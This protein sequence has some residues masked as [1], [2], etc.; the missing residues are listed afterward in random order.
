[1]WCRGGGACRPAGRPT[2][3]CRP[4][5]ARRALG[6]RLSPFDGGAAIGA[7]RRRRALFRRSRTIAHTTLGE[8]W[9]M[10]WSSTAQPAT[11]PG[12]PGTEEPRHHGHHRRSAA[13]RTAGQHDRGTE[14]EPGQREVVSQAHHPPSL[15]ASECGTGGHDRGDQ[16]GEPD[17][18][19]SSERLARC[20]E[21]LVERSGRAGDDHGR[22]HT[23]HRP[24]QCA[25]P[26]TTGDRDEPFD[27]PANEHRERCCQDD[28]RDRPPLP[29]PRRAGAAARDAS[30]VLTSFSIV[31]RRE[32]LSGSPTP[33]RR[34]TATPWTVRRSSTG[35]RVEHADR[36]AELVLRGRGRSRRPG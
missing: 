22:D 30:G 26:V 32:R 16:D 27:R 6:V 7:A 15:R 17:A 2:C 19:R 4:C 14:P 31:V 23:G 10:G 1:M 24:H 35:T 28:R 5:P 11:A 21:V 25:D 8:R 20:L 34:R 36:V 13:M 29:R 33:L 12:G 18:W 3:P 9:S